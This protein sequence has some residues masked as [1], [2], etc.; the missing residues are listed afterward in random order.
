MNANNFWP[1][2]A[3]TLVAG[4]STGIGGLIAVYGAKGKRFLPLS[5]GLSAGVMI[6]VSFVELFQMAFDTLAVDYGDKT[7]MMLTVLGFFIGIAIIFCIDQL[8][9]ENINPHEISPP[10]D[11]PRDRGMHGVKSDSSEMQRLRRVGLMAALAIVIHNFPEGIATF[12]SGLQDIR[13]GLAI[14]VA[15]AIHN[16]PEGMAVAVPIYYADGNRK[17]ALQYAFLSGLAEPIGALFGALLLW[18]FMNGA[19]FGMILSGVAGIMVFISLDELL[20]AAEAYGE[21]HLSIIG[22]VVGMAIMA[23]TLLLL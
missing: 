4:V 7:G 1:A 18:R 12:A 5:L 23:A 10:R 6:Y 2:L 13:M 15:V 20:P 19:L 14:C 21:H 17:L 3:M 9:P 16:I 22:V 11:A 8:L